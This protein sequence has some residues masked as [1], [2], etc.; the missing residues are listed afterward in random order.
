MTLGVHSVFLLI[1][2]IWRNIVLLQRKV[3]YRNLNDKS[4]QNVLTASLFIWTIVAIFFFITLVMAWNTICVIEFVRFTG[5]LPSITFGS[6]CKNKTPNVLSC[7][8]PQNKSSSDLYTGCPS[9]VFRSLRAHNSEKMH[10]WPHVGKVK[11]HL[12]GGNFLNL[13]EFV[14]F[15]S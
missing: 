7:S 8:R 2:D 6:G 1:L 10:F 9:F 13:Q 3:S 11:M 15:L 12:R 4:W 5:K 14:T